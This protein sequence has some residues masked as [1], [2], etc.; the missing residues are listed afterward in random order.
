MPSLTPLRI[1]F[2]GSSFVQGIK[3][4]LLRLVNTSGRVATIH[5]RSVARWTLGYHAT[6]PETISRIENGDYDFVILQEQSDGCTAQWSYPYIRSLNTRIR[7]AGGK[8]V[9]MM[10]WRDRGAK[11]STYDSLRGVQGGTVGYVPVALEEAVDAAVAPV[12]W[13]YRAAIT[14]SPNINLWMSDG[15]HANPRGHYLAALSIYCAIYRVSPVGLGAPGP[16]ALVKAHD[17]ALVNT[18]ALGTRAD[19]NID[20]A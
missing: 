15:H 17:Q 12:G 10:T 18:V 9:L 8:P 11:L 14:E 6:S 3:D 16:L 1:L 20:P 19:W 13:V 4:P 2:V 7:N 5:V